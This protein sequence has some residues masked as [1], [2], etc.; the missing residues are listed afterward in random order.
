[1]PQTMRAYWHS[2]CDFLV[3]YF[4]CAEQYRICKNCGIHSKISPSSKRTFGGD[5]L[6]CCQIR[7]V[8]DYHGELEEHKVEMRRTFEI[9][10]HRVPLKDHRVLM[11]PADGT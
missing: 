10:S 9:A 6:T 3:P 11:E 5:H 7:V 4:R 8:E 2:D 1:M